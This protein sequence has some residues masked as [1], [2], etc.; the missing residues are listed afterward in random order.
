MTSFMIP[1]KSTLASK[2]LNLEAKKSLN[3]ELKGPI[4]KLKSIRLNLKLKGGI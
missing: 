3:V 2:L 1:K 4:R